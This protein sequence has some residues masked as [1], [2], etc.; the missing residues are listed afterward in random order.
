MLDGLDLGACDAVG[1][2][3]GRHG[4]RLEQRG[5]L[6]LAAADVL[7]QGARRLLGLGEEGFQLRDGREGHGATHKAGD[8]LGVGVGFGVLVELAPAAQASRGSSGTSG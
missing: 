6:L 1:E 7:L 5:E 8:G 2:L 4:T 3:L